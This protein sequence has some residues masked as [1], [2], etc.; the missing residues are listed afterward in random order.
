MA[1]KTFLHFVKLEY[2]ASNQPC[3]RNSPSISLTQII[4]KSSV[5]DCLI[6]KPRGDNAARP[7]VCSMFSTE[8]HIRAAS[9]ARAHRMLKLAQQ[10]TACST[11]ATAGDAAAPAACRITF[12]AHACTSFATTLYEA[13]T[14]SQTGTRTA[15]SAA[16]CDSLAAART[17]STR[18]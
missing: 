17:V 4:K 10:C 7:P 18:A 16:G 5:Q 13:G 2:A 1:F 15:A 6:F 11:D 9:S 14:A 12:I 8:T 3:D